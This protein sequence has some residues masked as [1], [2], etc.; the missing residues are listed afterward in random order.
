M[1]TSNNISKIPPFAGLPFFK[2]CISH[3]TASFAVTT[4]RSWRYEMGKEIY[5]K[6]KRLLITTDGGG[7]NSSRSRLWK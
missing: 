7:S 2:L 6:A 4:I 5:T 3:D 1:K